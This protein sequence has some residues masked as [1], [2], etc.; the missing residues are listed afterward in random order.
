MAG[1]TFVAYHI[2][3]SIVW[4]RR[5]HNNPWKT[6]FWLT[7]STINALIRINHEHIKMAPIPKKTTKIAIGITPTDV[8]LK[9]E[10][11]IRLRKIFSKST[12]TFHYSP[13]LIST[14]GQFHC[15]VSFYGTPKTVRHSINLHLVVNTLC[16]FN[17][18]IWKHVD[19]SL[20]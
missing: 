1:S 18:F 8:G 13:F 17:Y 4:N 2:C 6:T 16:I 5:H 9:V 19:P 3:V 20:F 12:N 15:P 11:T 7:Y 14:E 10:L